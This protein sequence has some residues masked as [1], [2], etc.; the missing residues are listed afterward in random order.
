L[1]LSAGRA[2]LDLYCPADRLTAAN[3]LQQHAAA[4]TCKR[5]AEQQQQQ[6]RPFN[7]L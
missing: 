6:Q 5:Q 7:G 2:A 4:D 1:L 3:L